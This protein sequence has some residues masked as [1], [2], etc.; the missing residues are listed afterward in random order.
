M[1]VQTRKVTTY[2]CDRCKH[3]TEEPLDF[4]SCVDIIASTTV[5]AMNG[6]IGGYKEE[7]WLC[8]SCTVAFQSFMKG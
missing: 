4:N 7:Y 2:S 5:K 3:E 1:G 6:D 8:G